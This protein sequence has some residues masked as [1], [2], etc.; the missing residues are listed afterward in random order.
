MKTCP[1]CG[2]LYSNTV[3]TCPNCNVSLDSTANGTS[4]SNVQPHT[5]PPICVD[6]APSYI[7]EEPA[8]AVKVKTKKDFL[9]LPENKKLASTINIGAYICYIS[10]I[11]TI[12][13]L[14]VL[15]D[16]IPVLNILLEALVVGLGITIQ[17]TKNKLWVI[18]L[19]G[20]G[21]TGMVV[22]YMQMGEFKGYYLPICGAISLYGIYKADKA[23]KEYSQS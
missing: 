9:A 14:W 11:I 16:W 3:T 1:K 15:Y 17:V 6:S 8:S 5:Q 7:R 22:S 20:Y 10:A 19:I 2:R 12:V 4:G 21:I 13:Y 18:V 23:W